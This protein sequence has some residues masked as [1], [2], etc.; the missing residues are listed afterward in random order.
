MI[1]TDEGAFSHPSAIFSII[2]INVKV[3]IKVSVV[4]STPRPTASNQEYQ[5]KT[6]EKT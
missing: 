4:P 5:M 2:I 1:K 3:I 6:Q